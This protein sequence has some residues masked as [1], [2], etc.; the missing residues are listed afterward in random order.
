MDLH[1]ETCQ[2]NISYNRTTKMQPFRQ[3]TFQT[4][5]HSRLPL[6]D[7]TRLPLHDYTWS[8]T[9]YYQL[10]GSSRQNRPGLTQDFNF[11]NFQVLGNG[12]LLV[13]VWYTQSV[14]VRADALFSLSS[15]SLVLELKCTA[16]SWNS[17]FKSSSPVTL[18][19]LNSRSVWG[20]VRVCTG[21]CVYRPYFLEACVFVSID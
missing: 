2:Y 10:L 18:Y 19:L 14:E 15:S 9:A 1:K 11:R 7:Y 20:C 6:H 21:T 3:V 13:F 5:K 8:G 4:R 16:G 12:V 17:A